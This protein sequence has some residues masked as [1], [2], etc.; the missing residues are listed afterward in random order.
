MQ[1][2]KDGL[3][4]AWCPDLFLQFIFQSHAL[5]PALNIVLRADARKRGNTSE[6]ISHINLAYLHNNLSVIIT[7]DSRLASKLYHFLQQ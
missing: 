1:P 2:H 7:S 4:G 6:K 5:Q 3:R